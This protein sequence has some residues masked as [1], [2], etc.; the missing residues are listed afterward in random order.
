MTGLE[1]TDMEAA[2]TFATETFNSFKQRDLLEKTN[3]KKLIISLLQLGFLAGA[4]W[5]KVNQNNLI[6]NE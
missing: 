3:N 1:T 4:N 2:E 6:F 5:G